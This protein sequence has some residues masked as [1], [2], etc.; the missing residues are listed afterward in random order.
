MRDREA[1][2]Q[3]LACARSVEGRTSP[4]PPV[5]AVIV[6]DGEIV[7]TGV[8]APPYGPHAEV[9]ALTQAGVA[10]RGAEL[11]VTLEPCCIHVHTPPCTNAICAAG[12]RRVVIATLD[13][14]PRVRT[15]GVEQLRNAGLHVSLLEEGEQAREA[16]ELVKPFATFITKA[17]PHVTAKWAM[18]LD[19]KLASATGD[20]YWISGPD[21][22]TWVHDLRDRVDAIVIGAGTARIDNPRLTVRIS[23]EQYLYPRIPRG[24]P[25]LRVV[26][27]T[28]GQLPT[29]LDLLQPELGANTC[30]LVGE[31]CPSEQRER[32]AA[33]GVEV[34]SVAVGIDGRI[35]LG[36]ALQVLAQRGIMHVLL[37]GGST[38]L[39]SALDQGYIDHVAA[40]V[41]P[42]LIGGRDAPTPLSGV[43]VPLMAHARRLSNAKVKTVGDDVLIEG[44]VVYDEGS[45]FDTYPA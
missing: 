7:S 28:Y 34:V 12:V 14:N 26:L 39:G 11:Y 15:Q 18:T 45:A 16:A 1:M 35:D 4:R 29:H 19:G 2:Q 20:A 6:R 30:V 43:G 22:R 33:S 41:A 32:L 42:K 25:P 40:F 5:G 17:R 13:P 10:A 8:T 24:K 36:A 27:A 38:L 31:T 21:A 3:A 44:D 9:Q 37:E 23:P